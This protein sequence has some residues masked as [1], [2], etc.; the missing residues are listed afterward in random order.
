MVLCHHYPVTKEIALD[1]DYSEIDNK[2]Y[3]AKQYQLNIHNYSLKTILY[4]NMNLL[5]LKKYISKYFG[6]V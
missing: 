5:Q 6:V 3:I 1:N 4:Y 2:E